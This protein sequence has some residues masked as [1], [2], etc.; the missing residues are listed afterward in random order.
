[1]IIYLKDNILHLTSADQADAIKALGYP[2]READSGGKGLA[3]MVKQ[4]KK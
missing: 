2:Y 3:Y 4:L 1:M